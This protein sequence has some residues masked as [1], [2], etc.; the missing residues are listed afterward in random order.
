MTVMNA[1]QPRAHWMPAPETVHDLSIIGPK[2]GIPAC[3]RCGS[4]REPA[5]NRIANKGK[6]K[7]MSLVYRAPLPS[8]RHARG[9]KHPWCRS[10]RHGSANSETNKLFRQQN[11]TRTEAESEILA[12][13]LRIDPIRHAHHIVE[14]AHLGLRYAKT[15]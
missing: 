7:R 15:S 9:Y 12:G 13:K 5:I 2:N 14:L 3:T 10:E 4:A 1:P 11:R 6:R 8:V